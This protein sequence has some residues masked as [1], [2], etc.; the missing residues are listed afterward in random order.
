MDMPAII[1]DEDWFCSPACARDGLET[2]DIWRG[3][4]EERIC[5]R[6]YDPQLHID[7]ENLPND[8]LTTSY[9]VSIAETQWFRSDKA[10]LSS[11]LDEFE[12]NLPE[13]C[14]I[15]SDELEAMS[16]S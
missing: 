16:N 15:T 11:L 5:L 6:V 13:F 3:G 4:D 10:D 14:P 9:N 8:V 12:D 7:T 1:L 2:M